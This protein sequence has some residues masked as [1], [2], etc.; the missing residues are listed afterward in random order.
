MNNK[1]HIVAALDIGTTK[2]CVVV[3]RMNHAG[4]IDILGVGK[5][6]SNGV[7]R[8]VVTNID[9]TVTAIT[10][11]VKQASEKSGIDIK[12]VYVGVAGQHIK[13]LRQKGML[14]RN[15][16]SN[17]ICQADIDRLIEDQHKQSLTPGD[18]I[19]HVIPQEY[20]V[21]YEQGI[22]EPI[23]MSGSRLEAEFQIITGQTNA[24]QNIYRC[25]EKAGLKVVGLAL[26]PVASATAVLSNE[27]KE[28]GVA[29]VDIGGGTTDITIFQDGVIR[30][31]AVIPLGGSIV[32][33]DIKEG[34]MVM[35]DQAEKLKVRFGGALASEAEE[36]AIISIP[37][38]RGRSPK[39]ISLRNLAYIIQARKEEILEYIYH[40]IRQSGYEYKLIGGIVLTGGGA[41][42]KH[43]HHLA[44]LISG[45]DAR[46]GIPNEH[47]SVASKRGL[48]LAAEPSFAT[49]IGLAIKALQENVVAADYIDETAQTTKTSI[50]DTKQNIIDDP[51]DHDF[52]K[53]EQ[54]ETEDLEEAT[55]NGQK[56]TVSFFGFL[57]DWF[58]GDVNDFK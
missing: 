45:L 1:N 55:E 22:K 38:L 8:G 19:I 56:N 29:L 5:A 40:E 26:E 9:K 37:G 14:M 54:S 4:T 30:H 27:E 2:V 57:K 58:E 36:N 3:A 49:G 46:I 15:H 23:G 35:R 10:Q 12:N 42:L 51:I 13:C 47:L 41:R 33:D 25:V 18:E 21:D 44:E 31:T 16:D 39:E 48:D 32:T 52:A 7:M 34:C 11:A 17:E 53:D 24:I 6:S 50:S 43:L 28:A 20:T